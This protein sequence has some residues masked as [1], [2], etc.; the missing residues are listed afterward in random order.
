MKARALDL[1][2]RGRGNAS[3]SVMDPRA[4]YEETLS[5]LDAIHCRHDFNGIKN[6]KYFCS[7]ALIS[8]DFIDDVRYLSIVRS[9][10]IFRI[11]T[12]LNDFADSES[13]DI[14]YR[15][16]KLAYFTE[17]SKTFF[18]VDGF[19]FHIGD[20]VE[21][22]EFVNS[23]DIFLDEEILRNIGDFSSMCGSIVSHLVPN[24]YSEQCVPY[25]RLRELASQILLGGGSVSNACESD[26]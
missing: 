25:E 21:D 22:V 19:E 6:Y 18:D 17:L 26:A 13:R 23:N 16:A 15:F 5:V 9:E 24:D 20:F 7:V 3:A 10:M 12:V 4:L 1:W 14:E 11:A 8:H 2:R